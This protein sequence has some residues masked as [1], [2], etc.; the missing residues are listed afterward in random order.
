MIRTLIPTFFVGCIL[1][2]TSCNIPIGENRY[3]GYQKAMDIDHIKSVSGKTDTKILTIKIPPSDSITFD[4][5]K[6]LKD[7]YFIKLET[8]AESKINNIDKILLTKNRI[9]LV[10][11]NISKGVFIFDSSG[12]FINRILASKNLEDKKA[13]I[14][15]FYDVAYD[16]NHDEIILHDQTKSKSYYFD[17]DG[18]FKNN[19]KEYLYFANFVNLKNTDYFVYLNQLGGNNHI[20]ALTKSSIY[21]GKRDTKI[22]Y[23]AT[24]AVH[25]MKTDINYWINRNLSFSNSNNKVFYTPEFSDTVYQVDGNP[26]NIYPK[27][28][29]HYPATSINVA[30]KQ[31]HN[32]N[33]D[34]Y[35][36]LVNTDQ[37]Y[38]FK[39]EVLCNDDSI[40]YVSTYKKGLSG[41]FY[42]EKTKK[43][44]GGNLVSNL[45]PTDSAQLYGYRY[46]LTTFNN[47]F[48]SILT[49]SDFGNRNKG[50]SSAKL[51]EIKKGIKPADNP[52][53]V[54]YK[55]KNF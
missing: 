49:P 55:L 47:Y 18:N 41:Y 11:F 45:L 37:Y 3:R 24:D 10:D 38:S 44:I 6:N 27:L 50:L 1:I 30:L 14:S 13:M 33:I 29:I 35:I 48:V 26:L 17:Q 20:P 9:I 39:G 31:H 15:N 5:N 21:I 8:I 22:L 40:Y 42:S 52:I 51:S 19:S 2:L 28:T 46:P 4:Y 54:F 32:E 34:A 7:V 43:I 23:T 12:R 16:Y 25:N 36:R 53:L